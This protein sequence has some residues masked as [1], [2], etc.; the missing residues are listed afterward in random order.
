M[1][2]V[3][4]FIQTTE[5]LLDYVVARLG[6]ESGWTVA[7]YPG[8]GTKDVF[9]M[10]PELGLPAAIV[11]YGS[12]SYA[13]KPRRQATLSVI[14]A[15]EFEAAAGRVDARAFMDRAIALL[16]GQITGMALFKAVSDRAI[17]LGSNIAAYEVQ[18]RVEDH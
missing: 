18:F 11:V 5:S 14:V 15:A 7:K 9:K 16:D 6:G 17:D 3:T 10:L 12:S 1:A 13:N 2:A 8:S 4:D